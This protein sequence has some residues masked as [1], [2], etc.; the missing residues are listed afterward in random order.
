MDGIMAKADLMRRVNAPLF[1]FIRSAFSAKNAATGSDVS[2]HRPFG[3]LE[4]G[5]EAS[6]KYALRH[7][8]GLSQLQRRLRIEAG[9]RPLKFD[10]PGK[11]E[12]RCAAKCA[13]AHQ[14]AKRAAP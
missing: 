13:L 5:P 8:R 14:S 6:A 11:R 10:V 4:T 7:P 1:D 3:E 12:R 9:L 2:K